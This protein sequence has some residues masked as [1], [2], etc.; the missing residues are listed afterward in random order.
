[1]RLIAMSLR[2]ISAA[3]IFAVQLISPSLAQDPRTGLPYPR[4]SNITFQWEYSCPGGR[5]CSFRCS[6]GG[7]GGASHV[8]KLSIYLGTVPVGGED[9]PAMFYN[10]STTELPRSNGFTVNAGLSTLS[11]QVNGMTLD[12]S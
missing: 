8:T 9:K 2:R 10:F 7:V 1:M 6:E 3:L 12:Y 11:C 4:G 5:L